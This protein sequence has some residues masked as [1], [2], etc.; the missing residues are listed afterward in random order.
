MLIDDIGREPKEINTFGTKE[1]PVT[2]L[3]SIR[4]DFGSLTFATTNFNDDILKEFYGEALIDRF[5]EI[6]N[7]IIMTG[8]SRRK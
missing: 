2:D 7:Y 5:H 3:M 6:F 8:K 4:Y 1:L